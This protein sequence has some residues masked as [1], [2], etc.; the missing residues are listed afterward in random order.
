MSVKMEIPCEFDYD[1]HSRYRCRVTS[2]V[3]NQ[4]YNAKWFTGEH[5]Y[6]KSNQDVEVLEFQGTIVHF[7]PNGLHYFFPKLKVLAVDVCGLKEIRSDDLYGLDKLEDLECTL[8]DLK[9]LPD[10]LFIHT[11]KLTRISFYGNNIE[12]MNS[13]ILDP[14]SEK[15]LELADFRLNSTANTIYRPG[16]KTSLKSIKELKLAIDSKYLPTVIRSTFDNYRKLWEEKDFCDFT[17]VVGDMEL[18]IHKNVLAALSPAFATILE[19]DEKVKAL[20]RLNIED[21]SE[22]VV[23]EF[24]C[25]MYTARVKDASN[26]V[27]LFRLACRYNETTLKLIFQEII[28]SNLNLENSVACLAIGNLYDSTEITEAAFAFLQKNYPREIVLESLKHKPERIQEIIEVVEKFKR[29]TQRYKRKIEK[30]N[31]LQ[32]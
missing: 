28:I 3:I 2:T 12:G 10:D 19:T 15:S 4:R 8:N 30:F 1:K 31:E 25:C 16:W 5:K 26:A 6:G 29:M 32:P 11:R 9:S 22:A 20:D 24:F 18:R 14:I 21:A 23:E 17:V 13:R 7:L 27:E